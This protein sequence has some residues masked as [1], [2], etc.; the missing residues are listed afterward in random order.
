MMMA[1][2][3]SKNASMTSSW[4]LAPTSG[5]TNCFEGEAPIPKL[6]VPGQKMSRRRLRRRWP[7]VSAAARP[8]EARAA[9]AGPRAGGPA[10]HT[11]SHHAAA[12]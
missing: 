1:S 7:G 5:T 9:H 3:R 10:G 4:S 11:G 8:W 6:I 12:N 2:A